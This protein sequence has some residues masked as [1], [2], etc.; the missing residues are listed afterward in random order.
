MVLNCFIPKLQSL[1]WF[2]AI[3]RLPY[4]KIKLKDKTMA[5]KL[6]YIPNYEKKNYPICKI[7]VK[8]V[9]YCFFVQPQ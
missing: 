5:D 1:K 2:W 7:E 3:L 9:G 8:T 4:N 6:M